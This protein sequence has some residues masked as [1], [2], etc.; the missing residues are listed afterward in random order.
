[1]GFCFWPWQLGFNGFSVKG[2]LTWLAWHF[3]RF[4][5]AIAMGTGYSLLTPL[6]Q[7]Q[8]LVAVV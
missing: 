1:V 3:N 2:F 4:F 5:I 7:L 6:F 8:L